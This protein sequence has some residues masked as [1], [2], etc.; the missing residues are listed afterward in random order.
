MTQDYAKKNGKKKT[1]AKS[2]NGRHQPTRSR[3]PGWVWMLAG[4][5]LGILIMVM[6]D[7]RQSVD[8]NETEGATVAEQ[9]DTK[10]KPRFDF[11][12]LLKESEI[13]VPDDEPVANIQSPQAEDPY[14]YVMQTGSFKSAAEADSLRAQLLL[15]NLNASVEAVDITPGERWHRVLV[16]P[17]ESRSMLASARSKLAENGI[18]S[19]LLKRK[20]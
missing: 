18:D 11:Y 1:P 7:Y 2:R 8:P 5:L 13:I 17:L 15:L 10:Y 20:K 19:L 6:N 9:P 14:V 3:A 16:G 12:T 4:V